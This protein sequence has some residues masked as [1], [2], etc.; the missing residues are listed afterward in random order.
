MD[1]FQEIF[2]LSMGQ[3]VLISLGTYNYISTLYIIYIHCTKYRDKILSI[4]IYILKA[5]KYIYFFY[6]FTYFFISH[7][8]IV[9]TVI[10]D[11]YIG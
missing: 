8:Y 6:A 4:T 10:Y 11:Y 9:L 7:Y 1:N 2:Y 3:T 5:P